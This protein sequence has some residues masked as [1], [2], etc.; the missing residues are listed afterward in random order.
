MPRH[1]LV[2]LA[3]LCVQ[4]ASCG[5]RPDS[6]AATPI[7]RGEFTS[8][9]GLI[10]LPVTLPDSARELWLLDSGFEY[11]VVGAV[12]AHRLRLAVSEQG[13]VAAPGGAV[14]LGWTNQLC[15]TVTGLSYCADSMARI[16]IEGLAPVV[17]TPIGGILGHD[18]FSRF[19]V[20]I[21]YA[22]RRIELFDPATYS[23][24]GP[25]TEVALWL[26]AGEPFV[27]GTLY[28]AGRTIPAKLKIDTGS[29]D[30]L[31]LNG[32]F[33][34]QTKLIPDK[35]L[36]I[37]APG[38]AVG[39][40]T[41]NFLTL[42][43]SFSIAGF[44]IARPV[45]GFSSDLTRAGDAGTLGAGVLSRF[46]ATFDYSRQRLFLEPN[47]SHPTYDASGLLLVGAGPDFRT[48]QILAVHAGHR[49]R[50]G[51][52]CTWRHDPGLWTAPARRRSDCGNSGH[53][54]K[55]PLHVR[56]DIRRG[57]REREVTLH[58]RPLL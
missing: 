5:R 30:L 9:G 49:R 29:L 52:A 50:S 14:D 24:R 1:T 4:S 35:H 39:G 19:V 36:R 13:A 23:Y 17:G 48:V 45:T 32:S 33:V 3:A 40:M 38:V 54:S 16:P 58:T 41:E 53:S 22:A 6:V 20:R 26:E 21:D 12:T 18:F 7:A 2:F 10:A 57:G 43:D 27:L 11:S 37:P 8:L 55:M 51:R 56:P 42:L 34:A 31:G 28:L 15:V 46:T 47:G 44:T 25:G